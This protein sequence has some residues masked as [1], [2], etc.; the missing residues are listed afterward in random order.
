MQA[1]RDQNSVPTLL[2]VSSV[3]GVTPVT[4]YVNPTTHRVLTDTASGSGTVTSVSVVSANGFAGTVATATTT[5]AITLTTTITGILSGNGTAISAASTTGSGAVVLANTPTLITPVLGVATGTSL[6]LGGATIG[7]DALAVTGTTTLGGT[8]ALGANSITMTG[9]LGLTGARLTKGWFTDLQVTNAIAG[10]ITGNAATVTTN[11]NLTGVITSSGNATSIAS[12]TGTGTKFVVDTS[13]TLITPV[14]GVATATSI[15][16]LTIST[17]TGTLTITNGKVISFSNTITFAG[18]DSTTMTFPSTSATI[19]R[20]D[21]A[22]TFTG[23]QTITNLTLPTNGQILLTVPTTDGHST[24]PTTNA[25]N[26]GYSSS[27]VG[28]L[29]YLDSSSTWQKCDANTL[30]LY[31]GLLGIALEVKASA[32]ALLVALPGSF[33]YATGFPT[34]TIG[35]PIYMSETAGAVT[36]TQPT[37]TDAAIRIVGWGIHADK[38]FFNPSGDYITHT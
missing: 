25:F 7:S 6:A 20:T 23:V 24:G 31:N 37:T 38:M 28:D 19:A 22:N 21:A 18:T 30:A 13:P 29:V 14:L 35:S 27:A 11:A 8:L 17:S 34:F 12:Q 32:A 5:P 33:V 1:S 16:S 36:Q 2:G 4:I 15:N 26:C 3:D 9:S 10:S